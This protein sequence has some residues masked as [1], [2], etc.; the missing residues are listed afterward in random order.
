MKFPCPGWVDRLSPENTGEWCTWQLTRLRRLALSLGNHDRCSYD[1]CES[2]A[3]SVAAN[4]GKVTVRQ[5]VYWYTGRARMARSWHARAR[6]AHACTRASELLYGTP[7]LLWRLYGGSHAD[8]FTVWALATTNC[9]LKVLLYHHTAA[10]LL[11]YCRGI[12][13]I[14]RWYGS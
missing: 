13:D 4:E 6:L 5:Y 3:T 2:A 11:S 10:Q 8:I 9:K 1:K 12:P 14:V 7:Y